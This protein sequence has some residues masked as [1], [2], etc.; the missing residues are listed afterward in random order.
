MS[1]FIKLF[2]ITALM[3]LFISPCFAENNYLIDGANLLDESQTAEINNELENLTNEYGF[4]FVIITSEDSYAGNVSEYATKVYNQNFSGDTITLFYANNYDEFSIIGIG[5]K[6]EEELTFDEKRLMMVAITSILENRDSDDYFFDIAKNFIK[7]AEFYFFDDGSG[8]R[9]PLLVDEADLFT[10]DE[11]MQLTALLEDKSIQHN[12]DFVVYTTNEDPMQDTNMAAADY[13]DYH[14]YGEEGYMLYINMETRQMFIL[15]TGDRI[16]NAFS[17]TSINYMTEHVA[18]EL[19]SGFYTA[20]VEEFVDAYEYYYFESSPEF[21]ITKRDPLLV[22]NARILN[23]TEFVTIITSLE[24]ESNESGF[25]L[26]VVID[27]N[28]NVDD[29]YH[30]AYEIY[31][32]GYYRDDGFILYINVATKEMEI[33][34]SGSPSIYLHYDEFE[35]IAYPMLPLLES[36]DYKRIA[37]TYAYEVVKLYRENRM[38]A[39]ED[40]EHAEFMHRAMISGLFAI[41]IT[42]TVAFVL[43]KQTKSFKLQS[44]ASTYATNRGSYFSKANITLSRDVY[45]YRTTKRDY[46]PRPQ[47]NSSGGGGSSSF[48]GSSGVSHGGGGRSF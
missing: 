46:S 32:K 33:N 42:G 15:T 47:N 23:E 2:L 31:Q 30:T 25:D 19:T 28:S 8:K 5:D 48:S 38:Q 44:N 20:A 37:D 14:N 43:Y 16:I 41:I 11:E 12:C 9:D 10:L 24:H 4:N 22:D 13:Y 26:V 7:N 45:L 39:I 34:A 17:D 3:T 29:P 21:D 1:K 40:A 36:G 18:D 6:I 27:D 35:A